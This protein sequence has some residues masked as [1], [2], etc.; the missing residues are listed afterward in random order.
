MYEIATPKHL[1]HVTVIMPIRN[2]SDF[3]ERNLG[4]LLAQDYPADCMEFLI[5]DGMSTDNTHSL[6]YDFS[7]IHPQ[8]KIQ[9]LDNPSKIVPTG[10]NI[11]LR[12]AIGEI[13]I[14]VDG[15][16]IIAPDY[17]RHCV[18][19]LQRTN[20]DN[21][22]GIMNAIGSTPFGKAVALSTSTPF[23]IG[24]GRFH[25]SEKEEWVD[26]VYM[27]AWPRGV[28]KKVG[29]FDEELV[30]DQDDEFNY[31]LR[32]NGGRILL[33]P[34]IKSEYTVRSTPIALGRQY[35]LYGYWKV[36]VMQKHPCQMSLHQFVPP[37]FVLSV[38]LSGLLLLSPVFR[39][40]SIIVPVVYL[41]AN[42]TASLW[43]ASRHGWKY[44][45]LLPLTFTI[46]HFS[47][48]LGFLA[49][50]VKFWNRWGDKTGK[51]PVWSSET[52]G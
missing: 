34:A 29:L 48:G 41:V 17:V 25:Y 36:R 24:S 22:G 19:T 33:S 38:L 52:S 11:A 28:F 39:P 49:G 51:V 47:Y 16:T 13:V 26:T 12:Q 31:R 23:G 40:L 50:L 9:I 10:M 8:L 20:A 42:L 45:Q 21:V 35:Y 6:I 27:G 30:R 46:L 14:R 5:A 44:L 37:V 43:V 2:E 18:E 3:I 4:S 1:P 32:E 15:H 7:V